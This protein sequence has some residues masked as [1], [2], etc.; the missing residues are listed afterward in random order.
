[1]HTH[2]LISKL[3]SN[4]P[5]I[6]NHHV[7]RHAQMTTSLY[8][9]PQAKTFEKPHI[10]ESQASREDD[11]THQSRRRLLSTAITSVAAVT[12]ASAFSSAS[13]STSTEASSMY[14]ERLAAE[15]YAKR[16]FA[17]AVEALN[18]LIAIYPTSPRLREMRAQAHVDGK[19]FSV[20]VK[21]FDECLRL[22]DN[23]DTLDRARVVSGRALAFEGL[24]D[25]V[26]ALK[27][28]DAALVLA[29]KL[30]ADPDPYILNSRGNCHASLGEWKAARDDYLAS[31]NGFQSARREDNVGRLQ[32]RLDGAVFAFSNAALMLAQL[33]DDDGATKEMQSIAR[34][35]PGSADMRAALAAQLYNSGQYE[36]AE[37]VWEFACSNITV[38]CS[39]YQDA[40]W[41]RRIRRWPPVMVDRLQAFLKLRGNN[42]NNTNNG[43]GGN[44]GGSASLSSSIGGDSQ[45]G[46]NNRRYSG[47]AE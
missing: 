31:A 7:L 40:D 24:G 19:N 13:A 35:A 18:R 47:F 16:D 32:Q 34:R 42:N 41:L 39:K 15:A 28:Y 44:G 12:A 1:M 3:G 33:G 2:S 9:L 20:A 17:G 26:A 14:L 29:E 43:G 36:E 22:I 25:W 45:G 27:D 8:S 4:F 37:N 6:Y 46:N 21:D 38:G 11:H 30:G 23:E 10:S 5:V